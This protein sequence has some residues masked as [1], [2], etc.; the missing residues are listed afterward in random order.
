MSARQLALSALLVLPACAADPPPATRQQRAP[1]SR[2]AAS[3]AT[4]SDDAVVI[5]GSK[6]A[7]EE[8]GWDKSEEE[9][10]RIAKLEA[11]ARDSQGKKQGGT[12]IRDS[13]AGMKPARP[14]GSAE[15]TESLAAACERAK[16]E[17]RLILGDFTGS[18]WCGWCKKLK[19]EVLDT[20]EFK[21]WA[22][23]NAVLLEVDF[24]KTK[25][26]TDELKAQNAMLQQRFGV[27]GY[28]TIVFFDADGKAYGSLGY[29]EGGPSVWTAKAQKVVDGYKP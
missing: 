12:P 15:W 13:T 23:Q 26:Q 11:S 21:D 8:R 28:P 1:D 5:R 3:A 27:K 16:N 4:E 24:P 2:P 6:S 19:A 10:A 9:R 7:K 18:D 20:P 25:A 14:A 22:T 29:V 17:K